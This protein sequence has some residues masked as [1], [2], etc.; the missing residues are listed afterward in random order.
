M[1]PRVLF[2]LAGLDIG[3]SEKKTVFLANT[4][5][6][7][8]YDISVAFL[9]G[10]APLRA[11]LDKNI[12]IASLGRR[13]KISIGAVKRLS[14][15]I[16]AQG[17]DVIVCMNLYPLL[18]AYLAEFITKN[19]RPKIA[20]CINICDLY[21]TRDQFAMVVYRRLV[22]WA[23]AVV[24]GCNQQRLQWQNRYGIDNPNV[25]VI[26][27]GVDT[28]YFC[29]SFP[30]GQVRNR[31][32]LGD[33]FIIGTIG[34]L[35]PE[36]NQAALI[37]DTA[38][39]LLTD[40]PIHLFIAGEG[41]QRDR[42][43]GLASDLSVTRY[44]HFLGSARDVRPILADMDVFILPSKSVETFSNAALEAMAMGIPVVLSDVGGAA[45]M[46]LNGESG[47]VVEKHRTGHI[48]L[49]V[50]K[51]RND[52][53]LRSALGKAGRRRVED[54]FNATKMVDEYVQLIGE[55]SCDF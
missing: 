19:A 27:N 48:R 22:N 9:S 50:E 18:Y 17:T 31:L 33:S 25:R 11:E 29:P 14:D 52:P 10:S 55:L 39:F 35:A 43:E 34:R 32:M 40:T 5:S 3:G 6:R 12:L 54:N 13:G 7:S 46:V 44:C 37:R 28:K 16:A 4:L 41:P 47:F 36:K 30:R 26:Y 1:K 42:L 23:N 51:L 53:S 2:L 20:V 15:M 21:R 49:I 8:G 45:E 38:S 24:F